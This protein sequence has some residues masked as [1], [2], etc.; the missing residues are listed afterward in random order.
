PCCENHGYQPEHLYPT[1]PPTVPNVHPVYVPQYYLPAVPQSTPRVPTHALTPLLHRRPKSSGTCTPKTRRLQ[2]LLLVLG[3]VLVALLLTGGLLWKLLLRRGCSVT[4]VQCSSSGPCISASL[5]CDGVEQCPNGEDEK[6][7]FRLYG[8]NFILQAY[9]L[10]S[11]SWYPV[12]HEN[13]S[14]NYVPVAC[15]NMGYRNSFYSTQGVVDDSGATSFM[16][17][18]RSSSST[19]FY[20]KL[21]LSDACSSR[22]LVSLRCVEC[23]AHPTAT[24][25]RIVG[26][27]AATQGQ[28]PWQVSLHF[29]GVHLCGGSII[30][31][32]WILTAAHCVATIHLRNAQN[33]MVFAGILRQSLMIHKEGIPVEK[34]I[35]HPSYNSKTKNN[36]I[37]L[38][39][40][41]T[42]LAFNGIDSVKPVCLPNPGL[43]L[44]PNQQS[45][46]SGW[47][48]TYFRG[49]TSEEL[50]SASVPLIE[51]SRCNSKLL[52]HNLI[53]PEMICAGFLQGRVD[54]CQGDSGGP[55][56]TDKNGIWW[57]IGDT[58]WGYGCADTFRPGVYA[59]VTVFMDWLSRQMRVTLLPLPALLC[60][61][62]S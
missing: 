48:A 53:T 36:D 28:W 24:H 51:N 34:V 27:T 38:L 2:L 46:I 30:T 55:L 32:R 40:L 8:P 4:G 54:A 7:C 42:P 9:S 57:L 33:W 23:G 12:C 37:A 15:T 39:K 60:T 3:A 16:K 45:W 20:K 49:K 43:G 44:D 41:Q 35:P 1:Q 21:T 22:S 14:E 11:K 59:N 17:L 47:G 61:S 6:Q 25:N 10:E 56:V 26:G 58:S 29:Q 31:P 52:Y 62:S 13:W 19:N 18:N 50:N 5:W